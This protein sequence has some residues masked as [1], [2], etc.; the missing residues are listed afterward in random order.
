MNN[1]RVALLVL[2]AAG[3]ASADET[4]TKVRFAAPKRILAGDAFLGE[5]RMYPS[6][7]LFDVDGDGLPDL[8]VGDLPGRV[9]FAPRVAAKTP[10]AFGAE[11]PFLDRDKKPLKFHNW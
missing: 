6:P 9:T 2:A 3:F 7:V 5:G 8:V 11:A 1:G 4:R 10:A